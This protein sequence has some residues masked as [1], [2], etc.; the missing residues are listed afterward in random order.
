[1]NAITN[2]VN[3]IIA[4]L[5]ISAQDLALIRS[6]MG[7]VDTASG[8]TPL[9][10][11]NLSTLCRYAFLAQ[12]FSL[13]VCDLI[14]TI[15]VMGVDPFQ[16]Q[17]PVSTLGFVQAIQAIQAPPFSIAQLNYLYRNSYDP[18]AGIAPLPANVSLLL[19]TLQLVL[20]ASPSMT[21]SSPIP[22]AISCSRPWGPSW[23]ASLASAALGLINGTAV[24]SAPLPAFFGMS[25]PH[26]VTYDPATL[27][28]IIGGQM[29][30]VQQ[31]SCPALAGTEL[32]GGDQCVVHPES[33]RRISRLLPSR[34]RR[35]SVPPGRP[36][37]QARS[38]YDGA[39]QQLRFTGPMSTANQTILLALL[40]ANAMFQ[41]AIKNLHQ[42]P[43]D[44]INANFAA[45]L[46]T[47]HAI[48]WLIE[49]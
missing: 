38:A 19:T 7:L 21:P 41:A 37:R 32:Y 48:K 6:Y 43:V 29:T 26:F 44:F 15:Q 30:P 47:T 16:Q 1:M 5:R 34:C 17:D 11:A 45:F 18:N 8:L 46:N 27:Q 35:C 40:P 25:L 14:T 24:Y 20:P 13:S 2:H 3:Q 12:A 42:Q 36:C 9:N 39:A 4:G 22:R 33:S 23:A 49:N 10:L 28:L 31:S